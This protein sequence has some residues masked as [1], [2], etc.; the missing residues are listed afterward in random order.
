MEFDKRCFPS[1][2]N[3]LP[4]NVQEKLT[5]YETICEL[6]SYMKYLEDLIKS[7]TLGDQKQPIWKSILDYGAD[8]T[9]IE[10]SSAAVNKALEDGVTFLYI[11]NGTFVFNDTIN[12]DGKTI[13]TYKNPDAICTGDAS[14]GLIDPQGHNLKLCY[15]SGDN[16]GMEDY[17]NFFFQRLANYYR[18]TP[19]YV[20]A[21]VRVKTEVTNQYSEAYEWNL[22]AELVNYANLGQNCA[23]YSRAQKFADGS[24]WA[25]TFEVRQD[26]L[27]ATQVGSLLGIE[28]DVVANG[29]DP[30]LNR[31]GIDVLMFANSSVDPSPDG[32]SYGYGININSEGGST[33][34]GI[35]LSG[36]YDTAIDVSPSSCTSGIGVKLDVNQLISFRDF[37]FGNDNGTGALT[38]GAD[39][40]VTFNDSLFAVNTT[41]TVNTS[42]GNILTVNNN[43]VG[44]RYDIDLVPNDG[45]MR[46]MFGS[47]EKFRVGNLE[48]ISS[49]PFTVS[50]G[51]TNVFNV[52]INGYHLTN[53]VEI[54][55]SPNTFIMQ[56]DNTKSWLFGTNNLEMPF[57]NKIDN[58]SEV[59]MFK[60]NGTE[61]LRTST[62]AVLSQAPFIVENTSGS[63]V[64][65]NNNGLEVEQGNAVI[66]NGGLV[67][68]TL[69]ID[70]TVDEAARTTIS[71]W[72][73][74]VSDGTSYFVPLYSN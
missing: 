50:L 20:N 36:T 47:T 9:G 28:V 25:A 34:R 14:Y 43:G 7:L 12:Y 1:C 38:W 55:T 62:L 42:V 13:T 41:F 2:I 30:Q 46:F 49:S 57:G 29:L 22:L 52:D 10:D 67:I 16:S 4:M 23:F 27:E 5:D 56:L 18:G 37:T 44:L 54:I 48:T 64:T 73:K 26:T 11:P 8:P 17:A 65:I 21:D 3:P 24:T 6:F 60:P 35:N 53:G 70:G 69:Q 72:L 40:I 74:I 33:F 66:S 61:M 58:V 39:H 71:K 19:G 51:G 31:R 59:I 15:R 32:N 63:V 68:K 45:F